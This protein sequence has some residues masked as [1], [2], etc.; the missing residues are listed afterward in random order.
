MDVSIKVEFC[1]GI[2][3]GERRDLA[4]SPESHTERTIANGKHRDDVYV[5]RRV[6]GAAIEIEPGVAAFDFMVRRTSA[7]GKKGGA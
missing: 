4:G 6:N 1:G 5:R 3:D 7:C 2:L